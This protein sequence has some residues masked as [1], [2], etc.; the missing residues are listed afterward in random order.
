MIHLVTRR[1]RPD[2]VEA[3][4]AWLRTV[5][6]PRRA[7]AIESLAAE[8]VAHETALLLETSDGPIIVY[9]METAD[10]THA[11]AVADVSSRPIDAEHRAVMR[12]ADAGPADVETLLD[13]RPE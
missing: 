8:G 3:V 2:E 10:L 5:D 12:R 4:R 9:A 6:G 11:R 1:I 7:E 13:L